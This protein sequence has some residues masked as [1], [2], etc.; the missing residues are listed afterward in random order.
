MFTLKRFK[1]GRFRRLYEVD[2]EMRPLMVMIGA[3]GAGKTS[4]LD[5]LSLLSASAA[6]GLDQKIN[7]M[8]GVS[9]VLTR[10]S[11]DN[12]MF[13]ANFEAPVQ[14]PLYYEIQLEPTLQSYTIPREILSQSKPDSPEFAFLHVDSRYNDIRYFNIETGEKVKPTW[15]PNPFET[16][17][18]Q[19]PKMFMVPEEIRKNLS[20]II[21]YHILDVDQRGPIKFPQRMRP[22]ELPGKNGED[23]VSLLYNLRE[24]KPE[25]YEL[26]EETLKAAFPGFQSL[27]FPPVA[28]GMLTMTWKEK[29]FTRPLYIH[30]LSEGTL[31][32]LWLI[33]LLQSPGLSSITMI[34]EPE[35]SLHPELLSLLA[36]L[37]REASKKTQIIVATQSDSL[38][39]FLTPKEVVVM[40]I[41]ENGYTSVHWADSLDLEE[42]LKDYSLDEVWR[43]GRMGGRG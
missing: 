3:N 13:G 12:L 8:G 7:E 1:I 30:Q 25:K 38:I 14:N 35:M 34:D 37:M 26:I 10:D 6:G 17:L 4:F 18:S 24:S 43:T 40:D 32:F 28:A 22:A 42:W 23:L 33:S 19:V 39:R 27:N 41:E 20:S 11:N 5:A 16:S 15:E 21:H 9:E 36:D 2:L 31:R 29:S